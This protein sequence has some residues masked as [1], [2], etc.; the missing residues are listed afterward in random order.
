M[1]QTTELQNQAAALIVAATLTR[2]AALN[3]AP[4]NTAPAWSVFGGLLDGHFQSEDTSALDAL[5]AWR[6][7]LGTHRVSSYHY[8]G[9]S[10][11]RHVTTVYATV[12]EVS[13][14]LAASIPAAIATAAVRELV[15]A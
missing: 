10:G 2:N 14:R 7:L 11:V 5:T 8:S 4:Q 9:A 6:R 12:D 1:N 13:V 3:G 15:A